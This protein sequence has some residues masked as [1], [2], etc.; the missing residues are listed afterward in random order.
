VNIA[1]TIAPGPGDTDLLLFKLAQDLTER[2]YRPCG[3]VQINT[4]CEGRGPCDMDVRVLP[5]GPNFRI[6]QSLGRRA[7][8]CRLDASALESAVGLV[9]ARLDQ[10]ADI[11]IINKFGKSEADGRGFRMVIA[12]AMSRGIPVLVGLNRLNQ[13]AFLEFSGDY[14]LSLEPDLKA[15]RNWLESSILLSMPLNRAL[16]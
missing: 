7:S 12:E 3:T 6:S 16:Q 10:G 9:Q 15:I 2:G 5:N 11:M 1:Y 14:A 13:K 8:G 4:E